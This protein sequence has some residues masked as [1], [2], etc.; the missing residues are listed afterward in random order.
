[1]HIPRGHNFWHTL[2][3]SEMSLGA[4]D[5]SRCLLVSYTNPAD[6]LANANRICNSV[7]PVPWNS[8]DPLDTGFSQNANQQFATAF[9]MSILA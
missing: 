7:E 4:S 3:A 9:V 2:R 1:M 8:I 5:E 6:V